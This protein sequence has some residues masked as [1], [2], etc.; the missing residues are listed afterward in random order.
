[1]TYEVRVNDCMCHPE[2][3]NHYDFYIYKDGSRGMGSDDRDFLVEIID[4]LKEG[5]IL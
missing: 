1:M 3:C 5:E 4:C 2:N